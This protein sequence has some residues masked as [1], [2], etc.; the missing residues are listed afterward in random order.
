MMSKRGGSSKIVPA[1][2]FSLFVCLLSVFN[3]KHCRV[4]GEVV[5]QFFKEHVISLSACPLIRSHL[6]GSVENSKAQSKQDS[7]C[8]GNKSC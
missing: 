1:F 6:S 4:I 5:G 8:H 3:K 7:V 2:P